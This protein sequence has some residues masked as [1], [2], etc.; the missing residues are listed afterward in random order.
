MI[1]TE[2][3]AAFLEAVTDNTDPACRASGRKRMDC[4]FETVIGVDGHLECF[5]VV[6]ANVSHSAMASSS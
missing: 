6:I 5:V 2:E 3:G 1:A 4:A